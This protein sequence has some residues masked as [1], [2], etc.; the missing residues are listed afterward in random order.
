[1][2]LDIDFPRAWALGAEPF[3][4]GDLMKLLLAAGTLPAA[5]RIVERKSR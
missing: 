4:V 2:T 3:I 5:W 1:M